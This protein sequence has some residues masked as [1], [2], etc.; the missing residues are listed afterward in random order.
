MI[1][2]PLAALAC[3]A[4]KWYTVVEHSIDATNHNT[5]TQVLQAAFRRHRLGRDKAEDRL[6]LAEYLAKL[7]DEVKSDY[8]VFIS[9]R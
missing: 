2:V 3:I 9:Y 1:F 6:L 8:H 5:H 7:E 4:H